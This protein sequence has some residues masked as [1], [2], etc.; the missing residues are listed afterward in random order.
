MFSQDS[1]GTWGAAGLELC[2]ILSHGRTR[3]FLLF[4]EYRDLQ[5]RPCP[6][7]QPGTSPPTYASAPN[8]AGDVPVAPD[9]EMEVAWV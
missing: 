5:V 4:E 7:E 9:E 2:H 3:T 8:T 6:S 1:G